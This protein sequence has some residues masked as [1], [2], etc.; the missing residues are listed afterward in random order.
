MH[1]IKDNFGLG[2]EFVNYN[3]I[4]DG[5]WNFSALCGG[6]TLF[7]SKQNYFLILNALPQWTNLHKTD[8]VPTNTVLNDH[9][10]LEIRLFWGF[11]L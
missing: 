11:G 4:K 9:E 10:K 1:M 2:L 5:S 3:E 6:P 8:D 7:F